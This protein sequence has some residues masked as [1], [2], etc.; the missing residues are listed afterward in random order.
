MAELQHLV[1]KKDS[2]KGNTGVGVGTSIASFS[3]ALSELPLFCDIQNISLSHGTW[4]CNKSGL[5]GSISKQGPY[6]YYKKNIL[7]EEPIRK[8]FNGGNLS[9]ELYENNNSLHS[10]RN[11]VR[12]DFE[13][14]VSSGLYYVSSNSVLDIVVSVDYYPIDATI[15]LQT[16][17]IG[18]NPIDFIPSGDNTTFIGT[19]AEDRKSAII[20]YNENLNP[21][22]YRFLS[23][24][25]GTTEV[26]R[27]IS[28]EEDAT[29]TVLLEPIDYKVEFYD[30]TSG[31]DVLVT[32]MNCKYD[33]LYEAPSLPT[34]SGEVPAGKEINNIYWSLQKT[35]VC[36][37]DET[38]EP[39]QISSENKATSVKL[40]PT[41]KNLTAVNGMTVKAYFGI[42]ASQYHIYYKI[43][44]HDGTIK[45]YSSKNSTRAYGIN[46][47]TLETLPSGTDYLDKYYKWANQ[48]EK[49]NGP[50]VSSLSNS[51]FISETATAPTDE[52]ISV[53]PA[54]YIGSMTLYCKEVPINFFI[55]FMV[56]DYDG[57]TLVTS[58]EGDILH[59]YEE[60]YTKP[61]Y[62]TEHEGRVFYGWYR[63]SQTI[64]TWY[65]DK[66]GIAKNI[67]QPDNSIQYPSEDY[68]TLTERGYLIPKEYRVDYEW[69]SE[70]D[71]TTLE[72]TETLVE[73][74]DTLPAA[75][76]RVYGR[77]SYEI[78]VI[79]KAP[80]N[81][82]ADV[83][84]VGTI[85][86]YYE[87]DG[88]RAI[89]TET[90]IP[91]TLA[92]DRTF[93]AVKTLKLHE[94]TFS[95]N[96]NSLGSVY[97]EPDDIKENNL[98]F[99]GDVIR[100]YVVPEKGA[101]FYDWSDGN[102]LPSRAVIV[103]E[104]NY[105]FI[106]NFKSNSIYY[107]GITN[108]YYNNNPVKAVYY[109]NELIYEGEI[110]NE[111]S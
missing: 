28:L 67:V 110:T 12:W 40:N 52:K 94:I 55:K 66:N 15:K 53:I 27:T 9:S 37:D 89:N 76:T 4:D 102:N 42:F 84:N 30:I 81:E 71:I 13:A 79:P 107:S 2:L 95:S 69:I 49:E 54:D 29:Y 62:S 3:F 97:V 24:D 26:T 98:Y 108:L 6:L 51:W 75:G 80:S 22:G 7:D 85:N 44:K 35:N 106:A 100:C 82:D 64:S 70:Y 87:K 14:T 86:W 105:N 10:G 90:T 5:F 1:L 23:W 65:I 34:Y 43:I 73:I 36:I 109:N 47:I 92:E 59:T 58:L 48:L 45:E 77:D 74:E 61:I 39:L 20:T 101:Y 56:Y 33:T 72:E 38:Y 103:G 41:F 91:N 104:E 60:V 31:S 88:E 11:L 63:T 16:K 50:I 99:K 78:P 46:D 96:N 21:V 57:S 93:Y 19:I 83:E 68:T 17:K 32:S 8:D 111:I 18:Q 25:D